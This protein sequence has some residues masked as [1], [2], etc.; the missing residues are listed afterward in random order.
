VWSGAATSLACRSL[1]SQPQQPDRD[2]QSL[3]THLFSLSLSLTHSHTRAHRQRC[4]PH[5]HTLLVSPPGSVAPMTSPCSMQSRTRVSSPR[6]EVQSAR[7]PVDAHAGQA[8]AASRPDTGRFLATPRRANMTST[9]Q[10]ARKRIW[11]P[12]PQA[13]FIL[14]SAPIGT[15]TPAF[16]KSDLNPKYVISALLSTPILMLTT[17]IRNK[18]LLVSTNKVVVSATVGLKATGGILCPV[19][20]DPFTL[21]PTQSGDRGPGSRFLFCFFFFFPFFLFLFCLFACLKFK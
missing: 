2:T 4:R 18:T 1:P 9:S 6:H 21:F 20:T 5:T 17:V 16:F 7:M 11:L 14:S 10:R 12:P 15:S 19:P 8:R 13:V 3:S